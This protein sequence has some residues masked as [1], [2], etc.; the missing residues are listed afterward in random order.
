MSC[1]LPDPERLLQQARTGN[2]SLGPLLELY[3]GYLALLARLEIGRRLQGKIDAADLVQETFL[4]AHR[5]FALFLGKTEAEFVCWLRQIL[6]GR[7]AKLVRHYLG[8][9]RRNVRLERELAAEL[10]RSSQT[11]DQGLVA[12]Q[13]SPSHQVARREQAVLLANAL[14]QLPADYREVL[15]LRHLEGLTFPE[16]AQRM[17]RT[18]L[19]VKKLWARALPRLRDWLGGAE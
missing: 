1:D 15:I 16:V 7:L 2:A 5:H 12:P 8:T 13:S 19:S 4:E 3:R 9:Q 10:D 17:G 6:A 14:E 11:L 18:V